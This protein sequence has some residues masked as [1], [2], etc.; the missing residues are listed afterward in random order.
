MAF[1]ENNFTNCY[2]SDYLWSFTKPAIIPY[3]AENQKIIVSYPIKI[4]VLIFLD[5]NTTLANSYATDAEALEIGGGEG[6]YLIIESVAKLYRHKFLF[7]HVSPHHYQ[8][9]T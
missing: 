5:I 9:K 1:I 8:V 6:A 2:F 3:S 7:I 4:H